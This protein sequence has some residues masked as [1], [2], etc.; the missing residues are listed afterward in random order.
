M[1]WPS[2]TLN[3]NFDGLPHSYSHCWTYAKDGYIVTISLVSWISESEIKSRNIF[4][5]FAVI[6]HDFITS[7]KTKDETL[8]VKHDMNS[9][10]ISEVKF[11]L[12]ILVYNSEV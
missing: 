7:V 2:W 12:P 11:L 3:I 10:H 5:M 4:E 9:V 1:F 8:R 6:N